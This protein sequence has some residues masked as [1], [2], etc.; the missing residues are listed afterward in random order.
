MTLSAR[1]QVA[2]FLHEF[3]KRKSRMTI[4]DAFER[5]TI[6]P[7]Q[8]MEV[9][10]VL[11]LA[12]AASLMAA[13]R[14]H[15]RV[16][17]ALV[18][19]FCT[20]VL[21]AVYVLGKRLME[22]KRQQQTEQILMMQ[23]RTFLSTQEPAEWRTVTA[24]KEPDIETLGERLLAMLNTDGSKLPR[25]GFRTHS[26]EAPPLPDAEA[27]L[28]GALPRRYAI[29]SLYE[30][31]FADLATALPQPVRMPLCELLPGSE[32]E[33][34]RAWSGGEQNLHIEYS[35]VVMNEIRMLA[36]EGYQR[37]R[38]GGV[39]VGGILFGRHVDGLVHIEAVRPIPCD[40]ANGPRFVLSVDDELVLAD[41]LLSSQMDTALAEMEPVGWYHSHTRD[42]I[43]LTESDVALFNRFFPAAWQVAL[44]VRPAN[45]APTRAGF[46]FRQA[47]GTIRTESSYSEF[48]LAAVAA[49]AA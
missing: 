37:M 26:L 13:F 16:V 27:A 29:R 47:D 35:A 7:A 2:L 31:R 41:M 8:V 38:H 5:H 11:L 23:T 28:F 4:N 24:I 17:L 39:E 25:Q 15:N 21:P 14:Q 6:K 48:Q 18:L 49:A 46:F 10:S 20:V 36:A 9:G 34:T 30:R 43:C 22:R 45:L 3:V 40:Y 33:E 44:V 12:I 42:E 19:A 32:G 1:E